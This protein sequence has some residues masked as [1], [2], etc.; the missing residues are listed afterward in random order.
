[1]SG[2]R[3]GIHSIEQEYSVGG[4]TTSGSHRFSNNRERGFGTPQAPLPAGAVEVQANYEPGHLAR[5][6]LAH[7]LLQEYLKGRDPGSWGSEGLVNSSITK[8]GSGR[9]DLLHI[10]T[11]GAFEIKP[12]NGDGVASGIIQ[13]D[14][15]VSS[16]PGLNYGNTGLVFDGLTAI[17][18]YGTTSAG[19]QYSFRYYDAGYHPGLIVYDHAFVRNWAVEAATALVPFLRKG[20]RKTPS[21]QPIPVH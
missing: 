7:I 6:R 10:L 2:S 1:M 16:N 17:T 13:I 19:N 12:N 14:D 5:G 9:L 11:N 20:P 18:L 3:G 21:P 15:Y 8:S 4:S